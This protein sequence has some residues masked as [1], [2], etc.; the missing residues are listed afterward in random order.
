MKEEDIKEV[1]FIN[2]SGVAKMVEV[3]TGISD[4]DNIEI[5]SGINEGDEVIS[6][7]FF[8]VSKRIKAGDMIEKSAGRSG[9]APSTNE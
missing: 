8:V 9:G 4:Y 6:G 1:V 2:D 5:L 7:P 3:K